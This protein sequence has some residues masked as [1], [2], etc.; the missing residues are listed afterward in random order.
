VK[1]RA[2][3]QTAMLC[4]LLAVPAVGQ[5]T[6]QASPA[7][8]ST[9][10]QAME[11]QSLRISDADSKTESIRATP[12]G[13]VSSGAGDLSRIAIALVIVIGVILLL[14]SGI[15]HMTAMP[16]S[17]RSG[18]LVTVLSRSVVSP[19]QQVLV[20]QVGKRLIVVGDSGGRMTALCEISDP[21][22]IAM[23]VG[24][25]RQSQDLGE[26]NP[27]SFLNLFRRANEPFTETDALAIRDS[28]PAK[29][30][31]PDEAVSSA[32]MHGLME[33]VRILQEQF[34][35]KA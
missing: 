4:L 11:N 26:R 25:T 16:G 8:A 18:K 27:K 14:R 24:Q 9:A 34:R 32:E 1:S 10:D 21:D 12:T 35:A 20:L 6:R 28:E 7:S 13:P 33:K 19:R 15:K 2:V 5:T 3:L 30:I 23:M 29:A 22:E 17:G 31:D